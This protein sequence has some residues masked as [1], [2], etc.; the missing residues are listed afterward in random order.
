MAASAR[1]FLVSED[2]IARFIQETE[3]KNTERKKKKK[4]SRTGA[5]EGFL[6]ANKK[7]Q[8]LEK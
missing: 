4:K 2:T 6:K 5:V 3:N 8:D 7:L 1:F